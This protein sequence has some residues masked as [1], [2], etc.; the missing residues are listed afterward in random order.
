[1]ANQSRSPRFIQWLAFLVF[2]IITLFSVIQ[3]VNENDKVNGRTSAGNWSIFCS[4][5]TF[6][7]TI[8]INIMHLN[9]VMSIFIVGTKLEGG[10]CLLL[11]VFWVALVAVVTDSRQG[12]AVDE[13]GAVDNGNLYYFSW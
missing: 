10:L 5:I 3:V 8:I 2:S 13:V 6:T 11:V 1:M 4:A 9:S 12:L 7:I